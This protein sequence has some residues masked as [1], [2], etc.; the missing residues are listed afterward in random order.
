MRNSLEKSDNL[1]ANNY[2]LSAVMLTAVTTTHETFHPHI[3]FM[4]YKVVPL[5]LGVE[6][7]AF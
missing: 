7:A 3:L 4:L 2:S 1:W 5:D 6:E